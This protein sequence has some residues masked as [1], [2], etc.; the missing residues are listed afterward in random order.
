MSG[1]PLIGIS[2]CVRLVEDRPYHTVGQ[3]Y[4]AG[5][6]EGCSA[7]PVMIPAFG[8]PADGI[9]GGLDLPG[10]VGRLDGLM[11]TGS[12]SN[13]EPHHYGGPAAYEGCK[14][15]PARD[16][17]TLPLIREALRQGLPLFAIC[18]GLQEL[19]VALGG[20]LHQKLWEVQ[21]REDHRMLKDVSEDERYAPR[22][23][24]AC[25]PDG[26]L[27]GMAQRLGLDPESVPVN[28]LHGQAVDRLADGLTLEAVAPDGTIEA[29]RVTAAPAIGLDRVDSF[30]LAVQWH[31]EWKVRDYPFYAALF[32]AF[33][34]AAQARLTDRQAG[35]LRRTTTAAA[36]E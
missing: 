14:A 21:G 30:A 35:R 32:E 9:A 27:A 19:N 34:V 16:A 17:T 4:I 15:D 6:M 2:S 36:A 1:L 5:L 23:T 28:T 31:P 24:I 18:R 25:A 10:L 29:A 20:T 8:L 11:L 12:P 3:K 33:G 26:L 22:H 13:V 7:L